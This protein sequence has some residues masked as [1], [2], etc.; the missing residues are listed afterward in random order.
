MD[1]FKN[2]IVRIKLFGFAINHLIRFYQL[3]YYLLNK[4]YH[5]K[6]Q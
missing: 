5:L 6:L 3:N 4:K 1:G 2:K